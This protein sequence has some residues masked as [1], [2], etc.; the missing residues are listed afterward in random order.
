M[1]QWARTRATRGR[2]KSA[3]FI[4][5]ASL[6]LSDSLHAYLHRSASVAAAAAQGQA[7]AAERE[8]LCS[9][10]CAATAAAAAAAESCRRRRALSQAR[11][12]LPAT[13]MRGS[14]GGYRATI[15]PARMCVFSFREG[16]EIEERQERQRL[17]GTGVG[18]VRV[19][20]Y[21]FSSVWRRQSHG[22]LLELRWHTFR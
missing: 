18:D 5:A 15:Q 13:R 17:I 1:E 12:Q 16:G 8:G 3:P 21:V 19:C 14:L 11:C 9:V 20:V 4:S 22:K 2:E 6:S 10:R 7:P